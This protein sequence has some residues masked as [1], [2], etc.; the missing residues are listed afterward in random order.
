MRSSLVAPIGAISRTRAAE[1]VVAAPIVEK[2]GRFASLDL[3]RGAT[4]AAMIFVNHPGD[5]DHVYHPFTHAEWNGFTPTDLIFPAFLFMVGV[6]GVFSMERRRTAGVAPRRLAAQAL[7]RGLTIAAL[8]WWIAGFPFSSDSLAHLRI[9]GVLPRIGL[10]FIVGSWLLLAAPGRRRTP[11][12]LASLVVLL[13]GLHT[14][15]L[16]GVGYDLTR[17]GNIQLA[18][19][20]AALGGHAWLDGGDPEG[21]VS[22][23]SATA[24]M[25]TGALAGWL[26]LGRAGVARKVGILLAAGG[27]AVLAGVAWNSVLPINK[28]LWTGSFVL[29][30]SGATAVLLALS[31][32]LVDVLRWRPVL[33]PFFTF[34]TNPLAAFVLSELAGKTMQ[35]AEWHGPDGLVV[36]SRLLLLQGGFGWIPNP[37]IASHGFALA[38]VS[39]CYLALR[40]LESRGWYLKV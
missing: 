16:T 9:P 32:L 33:A 8:G 28:H 24:T 6:A 36:S 11:L 1:R 15:L 37:T 13:L 27:A 23:I 3:L 12:F 26:L 10:V 14:F 38:M 25:L 34:G 20:R 29:L 18:V 17:E 22:T 21:I 35:M 40:G 31:M 30:T 5:W 2:A 19:D 39:L 4:V 7:V